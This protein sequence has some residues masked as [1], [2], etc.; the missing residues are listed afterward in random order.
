M[1]EQPGAAGTFRT[2]APRQ[3][4]RW[5]IL[6]VCAAVST[7]G[8]LLSVEVVAR[9]LSGRGAATALALGLNMFVFGALLFFATLLFPVNVRL[10][11]GPEAVGYRNVLRR[12]RFWPRGGID[13]AV[14]VPLSYPMR[15]QPERSIFFLG[16]DGRQL[17]IL[18]RGAWDPGDL[19]DFID[20]AGV[21]IEVRDAPVPAA[22]IGRQ[23]T[24]ASGRSG[25]YR[26]IANSVAI[27][28][29]IVVAV[30]AYVLVS[31]LLRR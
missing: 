2:V 16:Q 31:D 9:G 20:A 11:I 27:V 29:A 7:L 17:I 18:S 1:G 12:T 28:V 30:G 25:P 23:F 10:L 14:D 3:K 15:S 8:G 4:V 13:H 19:E 6:V 24:Q 5:P 22:E 26:T 21:R